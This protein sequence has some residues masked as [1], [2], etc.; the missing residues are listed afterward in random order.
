MD[1]W[2][3]FYEAQALKAR[4]LEKQQRQAVR[5]VFGKLKPTCRDKIGPCSTEEI[6]RIKQLQNARS[7]ARLRDLKMTLKAHGWDPS[8]PHILPNIPLQQ[9]T[10]H[11]HPP[12][13]YRSEAL[14]KRQLKAIREFFGRMSSSRGKT[15]KKE[16]RH[17]CYLA[18]GAKYK[19][20]LKKYKEI[21]KQHGWDPSNPEIISPSLRAAQQFCQSLP[22]RPFGQEEQGLRPCKKQDA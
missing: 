5:A 2:N 20:T 6:K 14:K 13:Y 1:Y 10:P 7:R 4:E 11:K 15:R 18:E 12:S 19:A 22:Q 3:G 17:A 21:M 8:L 16:E 9:S